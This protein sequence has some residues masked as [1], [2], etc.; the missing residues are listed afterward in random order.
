MTSRDYYKPLV[1]VEIGQDSRIS[2]RHQRWPRKSPSIS[3]CLNL[4]SNRESI[5]LW[6]S[7]MAQSGYG[8]N[9]GHLQ[10]DTEGAK[11]IFSSRSGI[12]VDLLTEDPISITGAKC[13]CKKPVVAEAEFSGLHFDENPLVCLRCRK[14]AKESKRKS[15]D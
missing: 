15:E 5:R 10:V 7:D 11:W 9:Y 2:Y 3:T 6:L 12:P 1:Q 13:K 8:S 14:L 4:G